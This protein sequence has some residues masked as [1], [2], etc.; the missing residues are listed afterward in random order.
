MSRSLLQWALAGFV[1]VIAAA[2]CAQQSSSKTGSD[3]SASAKQSDK[4]RAQAAIRFKD[5]TK[6]S[7]V[8]WI[9]QNGEEAGRYSILESL[10]SGAALFDY[11]RDGDL[12][13]LLPGGGG[14]SAVPR[15][16]GR[17]A[18][19]FRNEG[20][21][22][23][24]DVTASAGLTN[25]TLY[26]HGAF[27][28]DFN[29]DGWPD[30][31]ITGFG[32]LL[33]FQNQGDGTFTES[34]QPAG[35]DDRRWS[36][37]AAWGD[38]NGDGHPD[39]YVA[40][41]VNWSFRN[42]KICAGFGGVRDV[43]SPGDFDSIDDVLF[44]SNGD[45][46]FRNATRECGLSAGGKGLGVL[47]ADFDL[48]GDVDIYVAND[49]TPN[50]LYQNDG[51]GRFVEIGI[52]SGSALSPK[53]S[54][55]GSMGVELT[56]FNQ[57][58]R[59]DIWVTNY[60]HQSFA[61]YRNESAGFYQ[62]VSDRLGIA[63]VGTVHVGFGT[64]AA[65]FDGDGDGDEDLFVTNGHVMRH[66]RNSP[67]RQKP[68]L[69]QNIKGKRFVNVASSAG[70]YLSQAHRGRGVAA[71]DID[72]DGDTD[73]VVSHVNE[74]VVL[75]ANESRLSRKALRL[76]LVGTTSSRDPIGARA[77]LVKSVPRQVRFVRSGAS[78]FSSSEFTVAFA[79]ADDS[80]PK[81]IKI[82]WPHG[83]SRTVKIPAPGEYQLIQNQTP[84]RLP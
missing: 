77:E 45:G 8:G 60:E 14:F 9:A 21:W 7:G 74:P 63:A 82:V 24:T 18:A 73:L 56:D 17:P 61:L 31:L 22:R 65:D 44:L 46:T 58:G 52:K 59:P 68:L 32:G 20:N 34:S 15:V 83:P 62:H 37:A 66:S 47:A 4:N 84:I 39:L 23:F 28:A 55:D 27:V 12:D 71:G 69:F 35:L 26:S 53:A 11:D 70:S 79:I 36:T 3:S 57:D 10:G 81:R 19:L 40:H 48:D 78:Y 6:Q 64:V 16:T 42:H 80:W 13:I 51:K 67:L 29:N 41:Y 50:F 76:H 33:L 54:G 30:V 5:M 72:G 1:A 2:G 49:T 43:C 38:F 75:L 25:S